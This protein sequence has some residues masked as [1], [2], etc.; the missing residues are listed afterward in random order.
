MAVL[1]LPK[2]KIG[3]DVQPPSLGEWNEYPTAAFETIAKSLDYPAGGENQ[4]INSV[5]TMW[6]LPLTLEMP[7]YNPNHALHEQAVSQWQG[8]LAVIALAKVRSFPIKA[9]ELDINT[10]QS[11]PFAAALLDLLPTV[12]NALYALNDKSNPW[13]KVFIWTWN[14][15][16]V[17][18]DRKSVV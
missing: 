18:I 5:P 17:G 11:D 6:A 13:R 15:K 12:D 1:I 3:S 8:M 14:N 10:I 16:P 4:Q 2:L 9:R 7:L